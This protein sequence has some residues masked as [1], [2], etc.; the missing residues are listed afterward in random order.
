MQFTEGPVGKTLFLFTLPT[1]ASSILQSL[2]ASIN[3]AWVGRLLG[4]RALSA[5]ANAN[6]L[7]F[8]LFSTTF[9]LGMAA[10]VLVGQSLGA[11]DMET[12][13][14]TIGTGFAF[15]ALVSLVVA[16]LGIAFAPQVLTLMHTP[17]DALPLASSYLRVIF[18]AL[19]GMVLYMFVI[20]A[21]RGAGDA[22]TP[23]VSFLVAAVLDCVLNPLLIRGVGPI[24]AFGIAG[25]ALST[26]IAQWTGVLGVI[27]WMYKSKHFLR[28]ARGEGH[29]LRVDRRILR[30]LIVKGVPMGLSIAVMSSSMIVII[31]LVN[32][33]GSH[34]TAAYGAC[35]QL[36]N[37][38]QMP[39]I[40]VGTAVSS[41]AAQNV[42]A[43]R[44]DRVSLIARAGIVFNVILTSVL[45]VLVSVMSHTAFA[46]FLG[47][48]SDALPI[49][50][51]I[52]AMVSWSFVMLGISFVLSSV[53]RATGAVGVPLAILFVALWV[54]RIPF[55]YAL[56][57][58]FQAEA[59]WW[60]FPLGSV[61]SLLL[62]ILYYRFGNWRE[63][64]MLDRGRGP[65]D[66]EAAAVEPAG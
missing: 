58:T 42:G 50:Q 59:I 30:T 28:F 36:W 23:A 41:M 17:P 13:K 21:L 47:S 20:M 6:A 22:K 37:Y 29:Y 3:A 31:S 19:P 44:W 53:V 65:V 15:F 1:L 33:F 48:D 52:N 5:S 54:V 57:P 32:R 7:L 34:V 39:A 26:A 2:N 18:I 11:R 38:I 12:A 43:K 60:S 10:T 14:R 63:A 56:A 9:G 40:A 51:H 35:F 61:V 46:L 4:E 45:V 64:R 49:A 8:F 24:P 25:S 27:V 55:A 62:S 16:T 66:G